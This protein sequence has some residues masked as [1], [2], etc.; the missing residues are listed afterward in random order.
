MKIRKPGQD[1]P[2]E[3]KMARYRSKPREVE[4][5]QW[6]LGM[7]VKGLLEGC[8]CAYAIT[9]QGEHVKIRPG[10]WVITEPDGIHHYPCAPEVF[11]A[12]YELIDS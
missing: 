6:Q 8:G 9:I 1:R 7:E 5:I 2:P 11:T 4:A 10:D 12:N 3:M